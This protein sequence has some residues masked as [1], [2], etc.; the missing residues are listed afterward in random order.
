MGFEISKNTTTLNL[1]QVIVLFVA[2]LSTGGRLFKD[3]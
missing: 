3:G 2:L 1:K